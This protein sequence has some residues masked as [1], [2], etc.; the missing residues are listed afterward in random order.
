[1]EWLDRMCKA[2]DYLE[3]NLDNVIDFNEAA[4]A[5]YASP[6]HFQRLFHMI[7]GVTVADYVRKRR[8]T[9]AAQ[10]LVMTGARVIDVALKYGYDTPESFSKAFRKLHGISPTAARE[11]G[12]ELKAFPR[13]AFQIALKGDKEMNYK[14]VEKEAFPIV[15]KG[16]RVSCKDGENFKRIPAFWEA[17][18]Q[19][20]TCD[21]LSASAGELGILGVCMAYDMAA[22]EL[23][24]M[25][26]VEK[27]QA[28]VPE[29]LVEEEIPAAAW[30]IF[31]SVGP[32]PEAIQKV[33][34][35]IFSEWF[36]ATGYEHA[37]A[38]ELEVYPP[39]DNGA[40]DYR[41]EVWIPVIKK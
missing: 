18:C 2:L 6:F 40:A 11:P 38:P 25:V 9:L 36:P 13:I 3:R 17:C 16:I 19:D 21:R 20:G 5:A 24:Y 41:C 28:Q 26:A 31:E 33:W 37:D 29:G 39:G 8:L 30:A 4:K 1:M 15:G 27:G 32:M 14:I 34:G 35:R 22:E 12:A 10:E 23:T 7:T